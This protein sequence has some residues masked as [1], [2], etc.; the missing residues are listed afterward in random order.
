MNK[1]EQRLSD[2]TKRLATARITNN[3]E[4]IEELEDEI[5]EV[6]FELEQEYE[7]RY[8]DFDDSD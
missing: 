3:E 4:V 5:A 8:G 2:L 6:E 7:S 1:L